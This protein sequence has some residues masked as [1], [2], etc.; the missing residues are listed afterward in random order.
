MPIRSRTPESSHTTH[1]DVIKRKHFP[2]YLPFARGIHRSPVNC[3]HKGQRRGALVFSLNCVWTKGWL[4]NRN[5]GD[6]SSHR[7]RCDATVMTL[8]SVADPVRTVAI[9]YRYNAVQYHTLPHI[10]LPLLKQIMNYSI[11]SHQ[12]ASHTSPPRATYGVYFV[13]ILEK[14]DCVKTA[15]H[16]I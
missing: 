16:C 11:N 5:A 14:I 1:D 3:P 9:A 4:N 7:A 15:P 2:C 8:Q 12:K 13:R 6:L 10:A